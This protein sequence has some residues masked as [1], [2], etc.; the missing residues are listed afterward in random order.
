[1]NPVFARHAAI[2][3]A[4]VKPLT[5]QPARPRREPPPPPLQP[6]LTFGHLGCLEFGGRQLAA[7]LRS[8][9]CGN[10]LRSRTG[11]ARGKHAKRSGALAL[12]AL[13]DSRLRPACW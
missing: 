7:L 1:M 11:F 6:A 4:Q 8:A 2:S 13:P 12:D 9:G 5:A 10:R 3:A